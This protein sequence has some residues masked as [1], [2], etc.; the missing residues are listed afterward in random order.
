MPNLRW[1]R[2]KLSLLKNE[3]MIDCEWEYECRTVFFPLDAAIAIRA[4]FV[5][6]SGLDGQT[7]GNAF[8]AS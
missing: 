3:L 8:G 5:I 1:Q 4:V 7:G 2:P 6:I